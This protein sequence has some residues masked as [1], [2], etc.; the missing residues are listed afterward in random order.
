MK[1]VSPM[2]A[3]AVNQGAI[4]NAALVK[5]RMKLLKHVKKKRTRV[6]GDHVA[7]RNAI[8]ILGCSNLLH[9]KSS[10]GVCILISI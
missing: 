3:L 1:V 5:G 7:P 8:V 9:G 2:G 4:G 10:T 6:Q